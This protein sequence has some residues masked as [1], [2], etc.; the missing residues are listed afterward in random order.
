MY[1]V[2]FVTEF[3]DCQRNGDEHKQPK[4]WVATDLLKEQFHG[5]AIFSL[6]ETLAIRNKTKVQWAAPDGVAYAIFE[7]L[8]AIPCHSKNSILKISTRSGAKPSPNPFA[9]S[10]LK[11]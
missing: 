8:S 2:S 5:K 7:G 4:Q 10:A 6:R 3:L 9:Q 11:N 1:R